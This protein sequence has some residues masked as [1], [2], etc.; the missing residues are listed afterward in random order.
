MAKKDAGAVVDPQPEVSSV[1]APINQQNTGVVLTGDDAAGFEGMTQEDFNIPFLVILQKGSKQVD[2]DSGQAIPGAKAG[3]FFN[4]VTQELYDGKKGLV[5][6]PCHRDHQF[7]E[8][9]PRNDGGGFVA[10]HKPEDPRV[11]ALRQEQGKFGKLEMET[12]EGLHDL[13]ETFYVFGLLVK[14]DGSHEYVVLS[15]SSTQIKAYK[16]WMTTARAQTRM[17]GNRRITVPLFGHRYRL[18][19]IPQ[20]NKKGSW[21][22][23]RIMFDGSSALDARLDENSELYQAGKA[24]RDLAVSGVVKAATDSVKQDESQG[25]RDT[26]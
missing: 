12:D 24:F 9:V 25:D 13:V 11:V 2:E 6:I 16:N 15:F 5:F 8:W 20:D 26:F 10:T 3:M 19:T 4:S 1:P 7:V 21:Q 17:D 22:G 18:T 14:E 23:W